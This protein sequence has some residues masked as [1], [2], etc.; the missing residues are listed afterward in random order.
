MAKNNQGFI[1]IILAIFVASALITGGY[2]YWQGRD[3][4]NVIATSPLPSQSPSL[5]PSP[6]PTP[7]QPVDIGVL[8]LPSDLNQWNE[9]K[10]TDGGY[11]SYKIPSNWVENNEN[12]DKAIGIY[13]MPANEDT[14][15]IGVGVLIPG[16]SR[17]YYDVSSVDDLIDEYYFDKGRYDLLRHKVAMLPNSEYRAHILTVQS[18][19]AETEQSPREKADFFTRVL[20]P[21]IPVN[22]KGGCNTNGI[23]AFLS[24]AGENATN[25]SNAEILRQIVSTV[26]IESCQSN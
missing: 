16:L 24:I 26:K 20:I 18:Y 21:G 3:V 19:R 12:M 9:A 22:E 5:S 15:G 8:E 25:D 6:I 2:W 7:V 14:R 10:L 23:L 4:S 17:G 1:G 13:Q 11:F